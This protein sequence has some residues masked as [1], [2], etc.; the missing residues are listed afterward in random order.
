MLFETVKDLYDYGS[1]DN[2]NVTV[3]IKMSQEYQSREE[4]LVKDYRG[5]V[6]YV[7]PKAGQKVELE[8]IGKADDFFSTPGKLKDFILWSKEKC[9]AQNYILVMWGHG[10]GW[11]YDSD[12][13]KACLP[14]DNR[15]DECITNVG[16]AEAIRESG[17]HI[18]VLDFYCCSMARMETIFEFGNTVDYLRS[19][20]E[21]ITGNGHE[22]A[23][24]IKLLEEALNEYA[25]SDDL[26]EGVWAAYLEI[27]AACW[28]KAMPAVQISAA[29]TDIRK[30]QPLMDA[31]KEFKD[32]L[33][34]SYAANTEAIDAATCACYRC[35]EE[36]DN[37]E[38]DHEY[39]IADYAL[40]VS[41]KLKGKNDGLSSRFAD[42]H[43][44][45]K[46]AAENA[47]VHRRE[48]EIKTK[49]FTNRLT[50]G[51]LLTDKDD[52]EKYQQSGYSLLAFES[53]SGWS[54]WLKTN[55]KLP[56]GNPCPFSEV[57]KD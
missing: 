52:F 9:P 48:N 13:P 22:T 4:E 6:R 34:S 20:N 2:V 3:Q 28:E 37:P 39:D 29:F 8:T 12:C 50:Y 47:E 30:L 32:L 56:V 49:V 54:Q 42:I 53:A 36:L 24:L 41:L 40:Q 46:T 57:M 43:G 44:K 1:T 19:S 17:V 35:W 27:L 5:I 23:G 33:I 18:K 21:P 25:P 26:I 15:N 38:A 14:D 7:L 51:I 11:N 10:S 45:I 31:T 55:R 16:L